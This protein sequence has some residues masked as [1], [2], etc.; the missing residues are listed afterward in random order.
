M[1]L[2]RDSILDAV[3][4]RPDH[5]DRKRLARRLGVKGDDRRTLRQTLRELVDDGA[6]VYTPEKTYRIADAL[7]GVM[8][9]NV[10]HID[11][12]GDMWA[13]PERELKGGVQR[14]ILIRDTVDGKR[15]GK[16]DDGG[17]LGIGHRALVRIKEREDGT[18]VGMVMKR[19][20]AGAQTHMGVLHK[21]DKGWRIQ[22]VS[23][24]ARH[25]YGVDHVPDT[26]EDGAIVMFRSTRKN[27]GQLRLAEVRE[28]IGNIKEARSASL[29]SLHENDIPLGF[30]PAAIEQA[31]Q[32]T[33]PKVGEIGH[34][35]LRHLPLLTIDPVDA[36]DFDDAILAEP[37]DDPKNPGGWSVWVAIADVAAFVTPGS[38][39]DKAAWEK[40]NSVYLPD[41]VEPML[42][43]E[44]SSDLCSLR[45]DEDRASMLVRMTFDSGGN[46][47]SHKFHRGIIRSRAR[48]TYRQAQ[49][50]FEGQNGPESQDV[51]GE[52][53][54]LYSC[55]KALRNARAQREPLE[56]E[57]PERRVKVDEAGDVV[58]ISVRDRFDAHKLVEE[59]MVQANVAAAEA[60]AMPKS[61]KAVRTLMRFHDNP[62]RQ[63]VSDLSEFLPALDLKFSAGERI[64]PAR[65]NKLL[66]QAEDKDLTET[67]GMAV[68]RTQAQAIYSAERMGHFGLNLTHYAHFTS[69]IRR[70]SDLVVHRALIKQFKLGEGGTTREEE[71]RLSETAEHISTTERR[72]M[73]AER[74]AVD[75]YIA[76]Y[77]QDRVGATFKA[78][79]TGVTKFGLFVT[80]AETGADGLIPISSLGREYF[81]LDERTKSVIGTESGATFKFGREVEV[82]LKEATPVTGGLI[83]DMVSKGEPGKPPKGGRASGGNRSGK[84]GGRGAKHK[85]RRKG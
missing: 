57:L 51:L 68:L 61:G 8:V 72:A 66:R 52:L 64:T 25:D 79:I 75:R 28:T 73:V 14:S 41:R 39:L 31:E 20:G 53:S 37:D 55:Y 40:G 43:H 3:R 65:F 45:P 81:A 36:K 34:E 76:A 5:Y 9:V 82:K 29:I 83:F 47:Q 12:D 26:L 35:D 10:V 27:R 32:A 74:D 49:D 15:G 4:E 38:P 67:V 59:F 23:K 16:R 77:L 11:E 70:Y 33:M 62:E 69:P 2:S 58:D 60:L 22:P 17:A 1:T 80:L 56:I 13:D 18:A 48:L 24:K 44:L 19:L 63:R 30:P 78:R 85:R 46:K 42:P 50:A 6:L 21:T 84:K 71:S 7:P 54:N